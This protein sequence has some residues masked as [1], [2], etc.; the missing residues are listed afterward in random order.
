MLKRMLA[1]LLL[2]AGFA[3]TQFGAP[4]A[5]ARSIENLR[6]GPT[7]C[8]VEKKCLPDCGCKEG[9]SITCAANEVAKCEPATK[10]PDGLCYEAK[11]SCRKMHK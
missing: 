8:S 10:K 2:C 3:V 4:Q 5:D 9:C 1:G 11:C 6:A 7:S